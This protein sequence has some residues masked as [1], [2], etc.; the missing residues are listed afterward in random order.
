MAAGLPGAAIELTTASLFY[1]LERLRRVKRELPDMRLS[2]K[3][4]VTYDDLDK[5]I[6]GGIKNK[7]YSTIPFVK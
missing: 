5:I 7:L 3:A 2:W 6:L 4:V 1:V